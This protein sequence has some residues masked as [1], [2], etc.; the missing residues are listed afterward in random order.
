MH[1]LLNF[2]DQT[3]W[4]DLNE[5]PGF[6][7][8]RFR[9]L[10]GW[11]YNWHVLSPTLVHLIRFRSRPPVSPGDVELFGLKE[12]SRCLIWARNLQ[13]GIHPGLPPSDDRGLK[14]G[15]L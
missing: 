7:A 10:G 13:E 5:S 9:E 8:I 15:L 1:A 2:L 6:P 11:L 14:A 4:R 12:E 3:G